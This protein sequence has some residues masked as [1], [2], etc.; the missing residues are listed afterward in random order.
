MLTW[1]AF[2]LQVSLSTLNYSRTSINSSRCWKSLPCVGLHFPGS[3]YEIGVL[4][5]CFEILTDFTKTFSKLCLLIQWRKMSR[6]QRHNIFKYWGVTYMHIHS[7]FQMHSLVFKIALNDKEFPTSQDISVGI[8][9]R[10]FFLKHC[11]NLVIYLHRRTVELMNQTYAFYYSVQMC[12]KGIKSTS[13]QDVKYIHYML[14][15]IPS[16]LRRREGRGGKNSIRRKKS[17]VTECLHL[18]TCGGCFSD[19]SR[20]C[21]G[22][23]VNQRPRIKY[24]INREQGYQEPLTYSG[25]RQ[26]NKR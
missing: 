13:K 17:K 6:R 5:L 25:K 14:R 16:C 4:V 21:V 1:F 23:N 9:G 11:G 26:R 18:H 12:L 10:F 2:L 19:N 8:C 22:T 15:H 20:N 24:R 7:T 3:L